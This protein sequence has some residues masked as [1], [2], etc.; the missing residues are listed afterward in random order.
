MIVI[1]I[2]QVF[3]HFRRLAKGKPSARLAHEIFPWVGEEDF[4]FACVGDSRVGACAG[5]M[6][7][8]DRAELCSQSECDRRDAWSDLAVDSI[9]VWD[10]SP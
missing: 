5:S 1:G 2:L 9:G 10:E 3:F 7:T 4:E 6:S 8:L